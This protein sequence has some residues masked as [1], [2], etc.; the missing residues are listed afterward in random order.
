[1]LTTW[2]KTCCGGCIIARS[3]DSSRLWGATQSLAGGC[4][5]PPS[6]VDRFGTCLGAS[7]S[8]EVGGLRRGGE[9]LSLGVL[10]ERQRVDH[11]RVPSRF[12]G[13]PACPTL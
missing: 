13:W 3:L 4:G 12:A 8:G 11:E 9:G 5:R 10:V 7:G 2:E 6:R 1:M